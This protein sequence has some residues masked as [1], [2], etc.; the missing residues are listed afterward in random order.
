MVFQDVE[1]GGTAQDLL[2][3][4]RTPGQLRCQFSQLLALHGS[5]HVPRLYDGL[6]GT[7]V[8]MVNTPYLRHYD[9][10]LFQLKPGPALD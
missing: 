8:G 3:R 5:F 4:L 1:P 6:C 10:D 7:A 9:R 2:A